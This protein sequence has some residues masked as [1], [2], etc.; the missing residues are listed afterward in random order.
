MLSLCRQIV[1]FLSKFLRGRSAVKEERD[2]NASVKVEPKTECHSD[3]T[4]K[5]KPVEDEQS[6]VSKEIKTQG[7][8]STVDIN[9]NAEPEPKVD[10]AVK[11]DV[12]AP[13]ADGD[14]IVSNDSN[15]NAKE[16]KDEGAL[17]VLVD[18]E[19]LSAD[20]IETSCKAGEDTG[21]EEC[22]AC[23]ERGKSCSVG[24]RRNEDEDVQVSQLSRK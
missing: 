19:I 7:R 8:E 16:V 3:E 2:V 1:I 17:K 4:D 24:A 14:L 5:E 15:N 10:S 21:A 13:K 6:D 20:E 12:D 23:G 22:S 11:S 18:E 9:M